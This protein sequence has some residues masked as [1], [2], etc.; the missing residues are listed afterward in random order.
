[1]KYAN[2][3]PYSDS[4]VAGGRSALP[5]GQ[6]VGEVGQLLDHDDA[7]VA[8]GREKPGDGVGDQHGDQDGDDVRDLGGRNPIAIFGPKNNLKVPF[9]KDT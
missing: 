6:N 5:G 1:M 9:E 4:L 7:V 2:T 8:G 3:P